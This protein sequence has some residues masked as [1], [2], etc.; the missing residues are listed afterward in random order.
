MLTH[1]GITLYMTPDQLERMVRLADEGKTPREI[2][3]E[4]DMPSHVTI[5]KWLKRRAEKEL[6]AQGVNTPTR[7]AL[8][9]PAL[10]PPVNPRITPLEKVFLERGN[11]VGMRLTPKELL[12]AKDAEMLPEN[13]W[14]NGGGAVE[15]RDGEPLWPVFIRD[16]QGHFHPEPPRGAHRTN[17]R[18]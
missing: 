5:T 11:L 17:D 15:V 8:T 14:L 18:G 2:A 16:E 3:Q 13:A 6:E 7:E 12:D 1:G 9:A 10:T 4:P